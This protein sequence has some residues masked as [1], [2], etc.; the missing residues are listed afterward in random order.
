MIPLT[1]T[2][3]QAQQLLAMGRARL[4]GPECL[5]TRRATYTWNMMTQQYEREPDA[6][7]EASDLPDADPRPPSGW[8]LL[9]PGA[10][11]VVLVTIGLWPHKHL[12]SP[13]PP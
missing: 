5:V 13:R 4:Q 9:I 7:L 10:A 11:F 1:L 3:A 2:T 12:R 8:L 6:L